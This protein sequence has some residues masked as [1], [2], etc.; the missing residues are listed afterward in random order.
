M[1]AS[2]AVEIE[3]I[4]NKASTEHNHN[5]IL[6]RLV[7]EILN[8][9]NDVDRGDLWILAAAA[10]VIWLKWILTSFARLRRE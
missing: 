6:W 2:I 4:A 7:A 5:Y 9:S 1:V 3:I 8:H 10:S